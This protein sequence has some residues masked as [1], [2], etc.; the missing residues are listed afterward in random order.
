MAKPYV[1]LQPTE[2]VIAAAAARIYAA[3]IIA[4]RVNNDNQQE[5]ID[6]SIEEAITIARKTDATIQSDEELD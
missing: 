6:R 5:W 2:K 3:Y 4:G 1:T